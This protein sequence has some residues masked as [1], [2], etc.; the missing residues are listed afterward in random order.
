MGTVLVVTANPAIP[1]SLTAAGHDVDDVRAPELE[2]W[3]GD[4][5]SV[6]VVVLDAGNPAAAARGVVVLL[7]RGIAAPVVCV[8]SSGPGWDDLAAST[9]GLH[10]LPMPLTVPRLLS[11]LEESAQTPVVAAS[12]P[13]SVASI[14]GQPVAEA[15]SPPA[16]PREPAASGALAALRAAVADERPD[17]PCLLDSAVGR[18]EQLR[19]LSAP[20]PVPEQPASTLKVSAPEVVPPPLPE[21]TAI[22]AL[23][24]PAPVAPVEAAGEQAPPVQA[25]AEPAPLVGAAA[26]PA[27]LVEA[28]AEPESAQGAP[29]TTAPDEAPALDVSELVQLL[30]ARVP[31]LYS[32][33]ETATVVVAH[34]IERTGSTAGAILVPDGDTWRVSGE[35]GL[36]PLER[37]YEIDDEHWLVGQL[38]SPRKGVIV[39]DSDIARE[40]LRGVP[41]ASWRH[42]LAA[43]V[44]G[45]DA[46]LVL[47]RDGDTP[48]DESDLQRLDQLA[49]ESEPP[50]RAA[51]EL[52]ELA[53][54]MDRLRDARGG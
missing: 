44:P 42:L 43:P 8:T 26:E 15:A 24:P 28:A 18:H 33:P 20:V 49:I 38:V 7:E 41:L 40:R 16:S 48:F 10:L 6:A 23:D 31:E 54:R 52:R 21:P 53:R 19:E 35:V 32:V 5:E 1:M 45:V 2:Q 14:G 12:S 36:R 3:T 13:A 4:A 9:P 34:A 25:A 51:C 47:A 17:D 30:A 27:A 11:A 37:R 39:E 46:L 29:P 22:R 50:L